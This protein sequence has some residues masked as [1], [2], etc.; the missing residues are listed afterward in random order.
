[1]FLLQTR[2][3][4]TVT[5]VII[6]KQC[7]GPDYCDTENEEE[8][9]L[10]QDQ[11]DL[12]TLGWIH[13]SGDGIFSPVLKKVLIF[14]SCVT[15]SILDCGCVN[16]F[17]AAAVESSSS[18]WSLY[19][20]FPRLTPHR[21]LSYPALT[22]THTA[23]TRSCCLKPSLSSARQSSTSESEASCVFFTFLLWHVW[24]NCFNYLVFLLFLSYVTVCVCVCLCLFYQ[25]RLLQINRSRNG[26]NLHV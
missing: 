26:G 2:N 23:P 25:N 6:P 7:G 18:A 17:R 8:L 9:F 14:R 15:S 20:T 22:Y 21:R 24:P 19:F 1:M 11:Y 13:V 3:A 5:H 16:T 12:I 10:I 4:F